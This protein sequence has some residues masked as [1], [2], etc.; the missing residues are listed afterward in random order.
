MNGRVLALL[1]D[2]FHAPG[3]IAQFNRD[4]IQAWTKMEAVSK[5]VLVPRN[6]HGPAPDLPDKVV[7]RSPAGFLPFYILKA[8]LESI[9]RPRFDVIFCGHL[10]M[11]PLAIILSKITGTPVWL[12]LHGIEAWNKPSR[13]VRWAT[14]RVALITC[15]SRHTRRMFL[16]WADVPSYNVLVLP[17][18]VGEQFHWNGKCHSR[19]AEHMWAG[20]KVMLTVAR[21]SSEEAYKGHDRVIRCLPALSADF[22]NLI[23]V[24]A[25]VGDQQHALQALADSLDVGH[26]VQFLGKVAR[27]ELPALYREADLFVMPSTGE[28]FGIVFLESLACGT[29]V[30]AGDGD[31]ARDPLQDGALGMLSDDG[32]LTACIH[33]ALRLNTSPGGNKKIRALQAESVVRHFG[34]AAFFTSAIATTGRA[35]GIE[36]LGAGQLDH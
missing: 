2:S 33:K 30:I 32:N 12:Q 11:V 4:L 31:G 5:I 35:L 8:V 14:E 6:L 18:T 25:G 7:E 34:R 9:P 19:G 36:P 16:H 15:V 1:G 10:N 13:A 26:A 28:G 24:I 23:Y 22:D 20:K 27:D 21:L 3:G 29:P 17:N